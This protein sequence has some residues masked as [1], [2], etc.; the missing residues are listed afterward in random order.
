[1]KSTL[2][3]LSIENETFIKSLLK[4]SEKLYLT[5]TGK[6]R[7]KL[8]R[9]DLYQ[10]NIFEVCLRLHATIDTLC[11]CRFFLQENIESKYTINKFNNGDVLR[12]HIEYFFLKVTAYKDLIFKLI[13]KVYDFDIEE[14]IGLERKIRKEIKNKNLS[15]ASDLLEGLDIIMGKI[16]PIRNKIAHGGYFR[17]VD[18]TLIESMN[19]TKRTNSNKYENA[20]KRFSFNNTVLMYQI[21]LMLSTYLK[22]IYK[23]LLPIRRLI[24]KQKIVTT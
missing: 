24:E 18:L 22:L 21:E 9:K 17:D 23:E 1:M 8:N 20:I 7:T 6:I 11:L 14:N 5:K 13:N 4:R 3:Q 19:I 16:A 2:E 10:R 15:K 12:Y